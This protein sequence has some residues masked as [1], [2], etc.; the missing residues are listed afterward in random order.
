[1]ASID[2][3]SIEAAQRLGLFSAPLTKDQLSV[4]RKSVITASL[5]LGIVD[6][7]PDGVSQALLADQLEI[8]LNT[9]GYFT[10]LLARLGLIAADRQPLAV[11]CSYIIYRKKQ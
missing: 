9:V 2:S 8:T 7:A 10:R 1:M 3:T 5:Y 4:Y 11:G 6:V